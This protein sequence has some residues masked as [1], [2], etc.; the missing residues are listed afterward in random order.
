MNEDPLRHD[1]TPV[2]VAGYG[3]AVVCLLVPLAIVGALFAGF[4]LTRRNRVR[5]GVA[6]VALGLASTALGV[7]V[8]R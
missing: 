2:V 3:M 4:A 5:D 1:P 6:I 8:L 7:T